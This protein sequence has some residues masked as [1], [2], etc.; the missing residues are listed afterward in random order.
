MAATRS[1]RDIVTRALRVATVV[2]SGE[3]PSAEDSADALLSFNQ[4]I[5]SWQAERLFAYAIVERVAPLTAGAGAYTIGSGGVIN[6]P[7]PVKIE[8]AF[9]RDAQ[10]YDRIMEV[11]E[12]PNYW[13]AFTLK[14][15][16]NTFPSALYYVPTY[17]LG[18]INL[19][20]LPV[21]G[22]TLYLGAW[23]VLTEYAS[24]N[25]I[26]SLPPGYEDAYVYSLAERIS[27]EYARPVTPGLA[28]LAASARARIKQ[29]NLVSPQ[30]VTDEVAAT[31][32]GL[33]AAYFASGGP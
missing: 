4:M 15:S 27:V 11:V 33:S 26:T 30:V 13:A 2:G 21:A 16:G 10:N 29:N 31:V 14:S 9:T 24:L 7:R 28:Q 19:W 32:D 18:T 17:P 6:A 3:T 5:D 22:L 23:E 20:Q 8:Y 1:V 25:T 12:D